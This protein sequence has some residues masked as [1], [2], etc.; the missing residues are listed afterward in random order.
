MYVA[1]WLV[2][3][4]FDR[5]PDPDRERFA[6]G[7]GWLHPEMMEHYARVREDLST[8][9]R[10]HSLKRL[11]HSL[12][13]ISSEWCRLD[14]QRAQKWYRSVIHWLLIALAVVGLA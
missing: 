11:P 3:W 10:W 7:F 9:W 2:L 12:E 6:H 14:A 8:I 1:W 4:A 13:N 5:L